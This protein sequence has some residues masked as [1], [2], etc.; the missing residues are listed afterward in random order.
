VPAERCLTFPLAVRRNRF[1]VPLWVFCL[2][3]AGGRYFVVCQV[4][5]NPLVYRVDAI[6]KRARSPDKSCV[7]SVG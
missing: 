7:I 4:L 6:W 2:G 5:S 3:M 1:L